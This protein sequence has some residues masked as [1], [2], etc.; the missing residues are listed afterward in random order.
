M[1]P[2][3][4]VLH[5]IGCLLILPHPLLHNGVLKVSCASTLCVYSSFKDN[6]VADMFTLHQASIVCPRWLGKRWKDH[7][8]F[9]ET[10]LLKWH[11]LF[12]FADIYIVSMH[13]RYNTYCMQSVMILMNHSR[14]T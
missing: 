14:S 7:A 9:C 12:L 13:D 10:R 2:T 1:W 4:L 11:C 3:C 8:S 5:R 6:M